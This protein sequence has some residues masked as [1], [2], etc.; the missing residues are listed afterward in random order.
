MCPALSALAV[1][2][3]AV[4]CAADELTIGTTRQPRPMEGGPAY[5]AVVAGWAVPCQE[6]GSLKPAANVSGTP[7]PAV[8]SEAD[9]RNTSPRDVSGP[10]NGTPAGTTPDKPM[11]STTVVPAGERHN[12]TP[13]YVY[14]V[15]D[16]GG[17][18]TWLRKSCSRVLSAQMKGER[19]MLVPNTADGFRATIHALQSIDGSQ[20]ASFTLFLSRRTDAS[21]CC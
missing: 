11:E 16:T 7:E 17:F 5:A 4:V 21:V 6:R 1:E 19:F 3:S 15:T 14:G 18:F 8:T 13:I 9:F 2:G 12:K 10:L 20:G